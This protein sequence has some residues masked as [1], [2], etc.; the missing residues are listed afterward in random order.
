M[1]ASKLSFGVIRNGMSCRATHPALTNEATHPVFTN[2]ATHPVFTSEATHYV[3]SKLCFG[4]EAR[5]VVFI[6]NHH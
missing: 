6:S 2:E 3:A 4:V 1:V 5:S